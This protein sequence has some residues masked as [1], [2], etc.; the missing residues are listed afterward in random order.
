[1][2]K[3]DYSPGD[4]QGKHPLRNHMLR[5]NVIQ[6]CAAQFHVTDPMHGSCGKRVYQVPHGEAM[7]EQERR[8]RV[9]G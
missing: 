7:V 3:I 9:C 5:R 1:M 4:L 2:V 6:E 8:N